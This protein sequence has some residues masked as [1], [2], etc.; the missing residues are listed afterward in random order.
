MDHLD[1]WKAVSFDLILSYS[2][3]TIM[4]S[5]AIN[6]HFAL[7]SAHDLGLSLRAFYSQVSAA[8]SQ[9]TSGYTSFVIQRFRF[10]L[11]IP[12]GFIRR[13]FCWL[14]LAV[15][16]L[17]QCSRKSFPEGEALILTTGC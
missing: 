10:A 14:I 5:Y 7:S 1:Q 15:R 6:I 2:R 11:R 12:A 9:A 8:C 16:G 3:N 4:Q 13:V 17:G